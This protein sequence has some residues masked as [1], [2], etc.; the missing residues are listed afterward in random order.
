MAWIF[1]AH[2]I[3][4]QGGREQS[5]AGA[6][7]ASRLAAS[8]APTVDQTLGLRRPPAPRC[9]S[10]RQAAAPRWPPLATGR[11]RR[12]ARGGCRIKGPLQQMA[13]AGRASSHTGRASFVCCWMALGVEWP[14]VDGRARPWPPRQL[15]S[16]A[17]EAPHPSASSPLAR[18]RAG[19]EG[20][21][22]GCVARG[23]QPA[24]RA[25]RGQSK[26]TGAAPAGRGRPLVAAGGR[27]GLP[28]P[29]RLRPCCRPAHA[30]SA[31]P[32]LEPKRMRAPS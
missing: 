27:G 28:L 31:G 23:A 26:R 15:A 18:G 2:N 25:R 7:L 13:T 20:R 11:G 5:G 6:P 24:R 10:A 14:L 22:K 4:Q 16:P 29:M 30:L 1:V 19:P 21:A 32:L 3:T 9:A 17:A 12:R 8:G